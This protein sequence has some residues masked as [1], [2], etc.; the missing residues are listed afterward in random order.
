MCVTATARTPHHGGVRLADILVFTAVVAF[1]GILAVPRILQNNA[2]SRQE[3]AARDIEALSEALDK[4]RIDNG[5]Y[6]TTEQGLTAL[7][8]EPTAPPPPKHWDGPYLNRPVPAD[9]WG[10]GYVYRCPGVHNPNRFDLFSLGADGRKGGSG[11]AAD[12]ANW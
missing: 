11:E 2:R 12:I 6:P 1:V 4:Y 9:P 3:R 10:N 8:T 7:R 5:R